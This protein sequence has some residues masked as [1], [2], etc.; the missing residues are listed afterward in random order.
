MISINIDKVNKCNGDYSLYIT[1]PYN[2]KVVNVIRELPSRFWNND[3]KEW[4]VPLNKLGHIVNNLS[5]FEFEITGE[6]VSLDK[7]S[8][9][10]PSEF[11][12]KTKPYEHQIDGFKYGLQ[13]NKWLLGD[14]MGLGKTKQVIDIA[15][16]KKLQN[17]YKHCLIICGVNGL[18]WNWKNEVSVHSDESAYILGERIKGGKTVIGSNTDKLND[19]LDIKNNPNYFIITN[20]ETFRNEDIT[21]EIQ[22]LCKQNEINMI[23]IDEMHKCFDYD[24]L[25][26]TDIGT[27][28]IGDIVKDK[29]SCSV[30]SYNEKNKETEWKKIVDWHENVIAEQLLELQ[31]ETESGRKTIKCT[32]GHKFFT[33]NRG[34]VRAEDL[35]SYDEIKEI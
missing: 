11:K 28:K 33:K 18:K 35:T 12:F 3:K 32:N 30:L 6:Y 23:A 26:T 34:W 25:I 31:F 14:E 22:K 20:I 1:F 24:T 9:E 27:L 13:Y 8:V 29:I 2:E 10:I 7:P 17:N 5:E 19:V 16:A 21:K 15:V 4:E